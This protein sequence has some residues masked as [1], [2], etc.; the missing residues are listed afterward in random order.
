MRYSFLALLL[1]SVLI[2][3]EAR[4]QLEFA[5]D[6][7]R[8]NPSGFNDDYNRAI[9]SAFHIDKN[10]PREYLEHYGNIQELYHAVLIVMLIEK[11]LGI[12]LSNT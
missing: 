4:A 12:P 7:T 6:S 5:A 8:Q 1:S 11:Y 10:N 9:D 2:S 3:L